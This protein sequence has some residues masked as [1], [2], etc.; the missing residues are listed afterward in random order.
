V[1]WRYVVARYAALPVTW[2]VCGEY[3]QFNNPESI[4]AMLPLGQY[5]KDLDP[6]KRAMTIHAWYYRKEGRQAWSQPWYDFIMIQGGHKCWPE[7][8][9]YLR[10]WNYKPRKPVLESECNYEGI[11]GM[12][13][14]TIR[15][16]AYRAIQSGSFGY[17]Y[18]SHGLWNAAPVPQP[19]TWGPPT[20]WGKAIDRPGGVQMGYLRQCYESVPWWKLEPRPKAVSPGGGKSIHTKALGDRLFL[21]YFDRGLD[22]GRKAILKGG[23]P[24]RTYEATWFNPRTGKSTAVEGPITMP[25]QEW[26]LPNR[27]DKEDWMLIV[28]GED[29]R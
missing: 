4:K 21:V 27:P 2:L 18:G 9:H 14:E 23:N 10:G 22:P 25:K 13:P 19:G 6:Y 20:R 24:D 3:N 11:H 15:W 7:T 5:V 8:S 12:G 28:D 16:A 1:L 29:G 17:T 26:T